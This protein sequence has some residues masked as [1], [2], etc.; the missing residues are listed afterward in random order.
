MAITY[1]AGRR[2]Q[3]L[4]LTESDVTTTALPRE[5]RQTTYSSDGSTITH[6]GGEHF[7]A[8]KW[9]NLELKSIVVYGGKHSGGSGDFKLKVFGSDRT[10]QIGS[11]ITGTPNV[12][13][14][15]TSGSS[16]VTFDLTGITSPNTEWY[17]GVGAIS[18]GGAPAY[19]WFDDTQAGDGSNYWKQYNGY[20][21][22]TGMSM[23]FALTYV[24]ESGDTKPTD[25]QVGSRF[26]ETDTRKMYHY[27]GASG[28][29]T[30]DAQ[31]IIQHGTAGYGAP[32]TF[33]SFVVGNNSNRALIVATGAYNASPSIV[34]VKF[35]G[36]ES[37]TKIQN[38][39]DGNYR[40][41]L[42]ILLNPTV[43]TANVVIEWGTQSG[44]GG[45]GAGQMGAICY[46]F[47]NV[48]QSDA[49]G[50]PVTKTGTSSATPFIAITPA[51]TGSMII[52]SWF[53]GA[54]SPVPNNDETDGM[55]IICG[56]VDRS[57]ASQYDLS[58]TIGSSNNMSR[59]SGN[60][61]F[62]QIA[63][64]IK[65]SIDEWKEEGT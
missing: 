62:V 42:W 49:F 53:N 30:K 9:R 6:Y 50:T 64:E 5:D 56:G 23:S 4:A 10:T 22:Y 57:M 55:N 32:T 29:I 46:S 25:I 38:H 59:T 54:G 28:A 16:T 8:T 41:E 27:G 43:T 17:I 12:A 15:P 31:A 58:P 26:E 11:T 52:D 48:K 13:S 1:H 7:T 21:N 39:T 34:S 60:T 35:N 37:F 61:N 3:G 40:I 65:K 19:V 2:I 44:F 51:T 20:T 18:S 33:S 47:Y 36:T 24:S 14:M 45:A 63:V